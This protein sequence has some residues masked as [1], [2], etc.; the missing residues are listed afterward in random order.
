MAN[1][2]NTANTAADPRG[3]APAK[4]GGGGTL[5][6]LYW[7]APTILNVHQASSGNGKDQ[8][9]ARIVTEPLAVT[10]A[11]ALTPDVPV[12]AREIPSV[13][14]GQLAADGTRVTWRLKDGVKW[15]DGTAFTSDDVRATYD[16]IVNPKN[17]APDIA[18]YNDIAKLDTPDATT[19]VV[20]FKQPVATWWLPFTNYTGA[21]LQ[22]AQLALCPTPRECPANLNPIGT[23]AYKIRSFAPGDNVQYAINE[24]Y[25]EANAPFFDAIDY[26]GGGDAGT[27]AKAVISGDA[28]YAW[29]LQVTPEI[30]KQVTDAGRS[31]NITAG[32]GV[33]RL[34][35]NFT[36]PNKEVDGERSSVKA[37]HPFLTDAKVREAIAWLIDRESIAKNLYGPAGSPTCNILPSVPP[38]TNSK[39]RTCGFDV[40]RANR[41]LDEAGY[42][43]GADGVRAKGNVRL[44]MVIATTVNSVREKEQQVLQQAFRMAGMELEIKNVD[45]SVFFG[46][47]DN[48]DSF[49]RF[50]KDLQI[51][52]GPPGYPDAQAYFE[53][54]TTARIA[55]K[56]NGWSGPNVERFSDPMYDALVATLKTTF[57]QETRN[58]LLIQ[59]NDTIAG[60]GVNIPIVER[61]QISGRRTD[62]QGTTP[63][64]WD[65]TTWNIA[66][67]QVRR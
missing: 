38:Q 67:W 7:Q 48:P 51:F 57:D 22:K 62:L 53:A 52:S 10:T 30:L 21:I 19:V 59:C 32:S 49:M 43:R 13:A 15:S 41:L 25:R 37:P 26:K 64:P 14:N 35:V 24:N 6:L 66:Y 23:G 55:Q 27:A 54:W 58:K 34:S 2:A 1:T 16:Y 17:A 56:A 50:E 45:S 5:R 60:M 31:L 61:N 46:K 65:T 18:T 12:L 29:N 39:N 44:K 63:T 9:A 11:N 36:D 42:A 40:A 3:P 28:D 4:R 33:E 8:A 20:T 47:A